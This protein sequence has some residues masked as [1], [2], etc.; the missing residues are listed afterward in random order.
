MATDKE[1]EDNKSMKQFLSDY[2]KFRQI[3]I[4]AIQQLKTLALRSCHFSRSG[5]S[6]VAFNRIDDQS[7]FLYRLKFIF[8]MW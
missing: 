5:D 3:F 8:K 2:K 7:L 4:E 1:I 6:L